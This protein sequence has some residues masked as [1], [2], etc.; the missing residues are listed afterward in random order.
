MGGHQMILRHD[1]LHGTV[2]TTLKAQVTVRHDTHK[3]LLVVHHGDTADM[4]LRHD[5]QSLSHR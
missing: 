5:I 1:L 3:V 4:I 2:Q